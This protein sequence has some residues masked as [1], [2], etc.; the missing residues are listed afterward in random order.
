MGIVHC[1]FPTI[2]GSYRRRT[3]AVEMKALPNNLRVYSYA[4]ED[5]EHFSSHDVSL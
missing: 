4:S 2:L 5:E 1:A 3:T